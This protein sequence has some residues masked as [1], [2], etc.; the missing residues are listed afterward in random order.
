MQSKK[1]KS[2]ADHNRR[3]G[4]IY[5]QICFNNTDYDKETIIEVYKYINNK[6]KALQDEI[7]AKYA[8]TYLTDSDKAYIKGLE[9]QK[10]DVSVFEQF[11]F[12]TSSPN[13]EKDDWGEQIDFSV[14]EILDM[15]TVCE[16]QSTSCKKGSVADSDLQSEGDCPKVDSETEKSN[17]TNRDNLE[18]F[19]QKSSTTDDLEMID[20]DSLFDEDTD[21]RPVLSEEEAWELFA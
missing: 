20:I 7:D 8:Q 21:D 14:E 2:Q 1:N 10:R 13:G 12:L 6:N 11:D 5:N 3:L 9:A 19:S 4:A 15:P 16:V 17:L 18:Q